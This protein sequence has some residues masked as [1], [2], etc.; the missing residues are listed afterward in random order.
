MMQME[1][2]KQMDLLGLKIIIQQVSLGM[3]ILKIRLREVLQIVLLKK[4]FN[5]LRGLKGDQEKADNMYSSLL[6]MMEWKHCVLYGKYQEKN[7]KQLVIVSKTSQLLDILS[8][9][10]LLKIS[11]NYLQRIKMSS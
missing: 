4:G 8:Q 7:D 1:I 10:I 11:M 9:W 2:Q 3:Q 6:W 5:S